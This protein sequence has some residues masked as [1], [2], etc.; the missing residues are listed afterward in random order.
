MCF[1]RK[2]EFS[3]A[4]L[5]AFEVALKGF[6]ART[7]AGL[8]SGSPVGTYFV[9]RTAPEAA[10]ADAA[11]ADA[12]A[13]A[14]VAGA[15]GGSGRERRS[16]AQKAPPAAAAPPPAVPQPAARAAAPAAAPA[17]KRRGGA[18]GESA[19]RK[20]A[21]LAKE[22]AAASNAAGANPTPADV[23]ALAAARAEIVKLRAENEKL[24]ARAVK[25][26]TQ[27]AGGDKNAELKQQVA[28]MAA[29][30]KC[31]A[32]MMNFMNRTAPAVPTAHLARAL[33]TLRAQQHPHRSSSPLTHSSRTWRRRRPRLWQSNRLTPAP[34]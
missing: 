29:Q 6:M 4:L 5:A 20:A 10:A 34:L 25:A 3:V 21:R 32:F 18:S 9:S 31:G 30:M 2:D 17:K 33:S 24:L 12:T 27:V 7:S 22:A 14:D 28:V 26:E 13:A 16:T 1:R 11:A 23:G 15:G 8:L 19:A